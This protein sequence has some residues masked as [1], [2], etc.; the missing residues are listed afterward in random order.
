MYC[1][2]QQE[3]ILVFKSGS[4][5]WNQ[6]L[7]KSGS[8]YVESIKIQNTFRFDSGQFWFRLFRFVRLFEYRSDS[9]RVKMRSSLISVQVVLESGLGGL[10]RWYIRVRVS[11]KSGFGSS[12]I[13]INIDMVKLNLYNYAFLNLIK[14]YQ[15]FIKR[16]YE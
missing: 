9:I 13:L 8:C 14:Y 3:L 4:V 15:D 11:L 12:S 6:V 2:R 16:I 1:D 7:V 5:G 10:I